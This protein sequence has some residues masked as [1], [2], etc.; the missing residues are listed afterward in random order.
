MKKILLIILSL[1]TSSLYSQSIELAAG[2]DLNKFYQID[3]SNPHYIATYNM[4]TGF[5]IRGAFNFSKNHKI[6]LR[7]TIAYDQYQGDFTADNTGLGGGYRLDA[8]VNKS[9]LSIGISPLVLNP[10]HNLNL[11]FGLDFSVG[12]SRTDHK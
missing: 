6:P 4:G 5:V 11:S 9:V 1:F 8:S 12:K 7:L 10:I 2:L 3:K